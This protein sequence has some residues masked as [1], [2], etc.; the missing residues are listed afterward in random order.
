MKTVDKKTKEA[1]YNRLNR[2]PTL[3]IF[4]L[5]TLGTIEGEE[6]AEQYNREELRQA[7]IELFDDSITGGVQFN[8][9]PRRYPEQ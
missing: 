7:V 4:G 3:N 5:V 1:I 6:G 8:G 9:E 2:S